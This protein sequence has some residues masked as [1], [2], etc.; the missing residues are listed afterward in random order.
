MRREWILIGSLGVAMTGGIVRHAAGV[1]PVEDTPVSVLATLR[2]R[3]DERTVPRWFARVEPELKRGVGSLVSFEV[4]TAV[5]WN[6]VLHTT[7]LPPHGTRPLELLSGIPL[8]QDGESVI[9]R[10]LASKPTPFALALQYWHVEQFREPGLPRP[11]VLK[12]YYRDM[13]ISGKPQRVRFEELDRDVPL[14]KRLDELYARLSA[15]A[16]KDPLRLYIGA[17]RSKDPKTR[18]SLIE[19]ALS[20]GIDRAFPEESLHLAMD[21]SRA[22]GQEE[23]SEG[24]RMRLRAQLLANPKSVW[25]KL[26]QARHWDGLDAVM[27][28]GG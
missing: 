6:Y 26:Y 21:A 14:E 3:F 18:L 27:K 11:P 1:P 25:T 12:R 2:T 17:S 4:G 15:V 28:R 8:E 16:P 13:V 7:A 20:L 5:V 10:L 9:A 22:L 23:K 19:Q 24:Y